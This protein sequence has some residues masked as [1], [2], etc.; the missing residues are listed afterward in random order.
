M[1]WFVNKLGPA[2]VG[3]RDAKTAPQTTSQP[4]K[5]ATQK[6]APARQTSPQRAAAPPAPEPDKKKKK[7]WF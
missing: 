4:Q 2:P 5:G 1:N 3:S 6:S 7:G